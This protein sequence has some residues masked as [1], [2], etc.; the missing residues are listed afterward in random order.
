MR[1]SSPVRNVLLWMLIPFICSALAKVGFAVE[2]T[3]E[4]VA[5]YDGP[6]RGVD[7]A[8]DIGVDGAGNICVT[9]RSY[10]EGFGGDYVTIKYDAEGNEIWV[11]TYNGPADADDLAEALAIDASNNIYVTGTS[12]G[13]ATGEDYTTIKYDADG[14]ELWVAR[15]DGPPSA[16]DSGVDIAVDSSGNV[17]VTGRSE[18]EG[19]QEDYATI[20]YDTSGTELWVARYNGPGS[21]DDAATSLTVDT[22]GN[23][24]VTGA[25]DEYGVEADYATIKY[26]P[27]GDVLWVARH[28]AA[29]GSDGSGGRDLA[30][31]EFGN[32]FVTGC[33]EREYVTVKYDGDG[34]QL[35]IAR[36]DGEGSAGG[37]HKAVSLAVHPAGGVVV[38]G[39][40]FSHWLFLS[41]MYQFAT[42]RYDQDGREMW[43]A[44]DSG[45]VGLLNTILAPSGIPVLT[46][47]PSG[48][49]FVAGTILMINPDNLDELDFDTITLKYDSMGNE[50]W[51]A[52]YRGPGDDLDAA[53]A[54]ALDSAGNLYVTGISTGIGTLEDIATIKYSG[55]EPFRLRCPENGAALSSA[56]TFEW[57]P[58]IYDAFGFLTVFHYPVFGYVPIWQWVLDDQFSI[59]DSWWEQVSTGWPSFWNILGVNTTT[60][61]WDMADPRWF[62]RVASS[63]EDGDQG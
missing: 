29:G 23:V 32:V 40:S 7:G 24:Y 22:S 42:I 1:R 36:Y 46:V 58:G 56:P 50:I 35:W 5:R 49:I 11:V 15:Y 13:G 48:N 53:S 41:E 31:D 8:M 52:Q 62:E 10:V 47:D 30:V 61:E 28:E 34:N 45:T 17:Y 14:N 37:V 57:T 20:K 25:S 3:E 43:V 44:H 6:E 38:T 19:T 63:P 39:W 2:P 21:S 51:A 27:N 59:S 18:G 16:G 26:A 54:L 12:H 55:Q 9:G 60:W 4:W 33:S